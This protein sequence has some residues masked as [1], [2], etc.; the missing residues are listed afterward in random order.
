MI[1]S[2]DE[3]HAILKPV[4]SNDHFYPQKISRFKETNRGKQILAALPSK[5]YGA[6]SLEFLRGNMSQGRTCWPIWWHS[7]TIEAF[8]ELNIFQTTFPLTWEHW[9]MVKK[10]SQKGQGA[11]RATPYFSGEL[12]TVKQ[13][14][15]IVNV[16]ISSSM[17]LIMD[18][19]NREC[20]Y[21]CVYI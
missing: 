18:L 17:N 13:L 7:H 10:G 14:V 20:I 16:N 11:C 6:T 9:Q 4:Y 12:L 2:S 19:A 5:I 8:E 1:Y 21:V 15:L 3:H